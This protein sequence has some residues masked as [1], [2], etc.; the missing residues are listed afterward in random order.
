LG[1][2]IS[3]NGIKNIVP[4]NLAISDKANIA[5]FYVMADDAY[6][7]LVDTGRRELSEKINVLCTTVDGLIG[8]IKVDFVKIDVEGLELSVLQ[9][10]RGLLGRSKPVIFCEI[11]KGKLDAYNPN[12]TISYLRNLGY[13]VNRIVDEK[14]VEMGAEIN[15]DDCYYN[16]FFLPNKQA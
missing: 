8:E 4:L 7:S 13:S 16:Y 5:N 6:S 11:Y 14:M 1:R 9:S 3:Q 10:M 12:E 15:H 2:N